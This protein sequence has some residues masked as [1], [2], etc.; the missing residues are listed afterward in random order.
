MKTHL[1]KAVRIIFL[2]LITLLTFKNLPSVDLK[3]PKVLIQSLLSGSH[4]GYLI[5]GYPLEPLKAILPKRGR[6]TFITDQ[7]FEGN[8]LSE[9]FTYDAQNY[10]APLLLNYD[11]TEPV[12]IIATSTPELAEKRLEETGYDWVNQLP[13]GMGIVRKKS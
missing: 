7:P 8:A 5:D 2:I 11:P 6:F 9:K 3:C 12:G 10:L 13:N 4:R 1:L